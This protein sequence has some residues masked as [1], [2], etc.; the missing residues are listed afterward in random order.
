MQ[1]GDDAYLEREWVL[2]SNTKYMCN[3]NIIQFSITKTNI[4]SISLSEVYEI[5]G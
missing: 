1:K 4:L 2:I 5:Y 3:L